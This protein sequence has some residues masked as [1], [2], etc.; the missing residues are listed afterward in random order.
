[1]AP[2]AARSAGAVGIGTAIIISLAV[3]YF[4]C[5]RRNNSSK[6]NKKKKSKNGIIDAIG[7]TPLI[8]INSLSDATGC[9][10][11]IIIINNNPFFQFSIF[12]FV[13]IACPNFYNFAV[14]YY[15]DSWQV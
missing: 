14:Y 10:V 5:D 15:L 7:N 1:M 6:N 4:F 13:S 8:R 12:Y 9:E 11:I 3:A 2:V